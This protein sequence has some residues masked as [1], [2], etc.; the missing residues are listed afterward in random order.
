MSRRLFIELLP[1]KNGKSFGFQ[2]YIFNLLIYFYQNR[3]ELRFD[4]VSIICLKGQEQYLEKYSDYFH[5]ITVAAKSLLMRFLMQSFFPFR[6]RLNKKDVV[7]FTGNYS[8]LFKRA[9]HVLVIH[10]LLFKN[11]TLLSNRLMRWQRE[12]YL[13]ISI[14]KADKVICISRFTEKE[15][16]RFY[17][18]ARGKTEVVYNYFNFEKY[19]SINNVA[20]ENC[21]ISVCSSAYHK[22]TI[23]VLKAFYEYVQ[24]GGKYDLNLVGALAK[25]SESALF[26]NSIE[27]S[28]KNRI[29]IFNKIDNATLAGLYSSAKAYISASLYEGLGMPI[30]EAMYFN[31]PVILT[32]DEVFHEVSMERGIYFQSTAWIQLAD[33]LQIIEKG[34]YLNHDCK[35]LIIDYYSENNTSAKY[36]KIVNS[37]VLGNKDHIQE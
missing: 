28:I 4:E 29:K 2:E 31:L 13:P 25:G 33:I 20:K 30:V 6:Y 8:A 36:V 12:F 22:N 9:N 21:F 27:E 11:K 14:K 16:L 7:L 5:I 15:V 26:Y 10:D 34:E 24:R 3:K 32:D 1:F 35:N 17:P 18:N 23:I 37:F 19:S